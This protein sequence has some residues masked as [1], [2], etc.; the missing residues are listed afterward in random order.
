MT[1]SAE[2][3]RRARPGFSMPEFAVIIVILG[4]GVATLYGMF[5]STSEEAFKSQWAYLA[6]HAAREEL[7]ATRTM[8][9]FGRR[10]TEPYDG[11]DWEV[12]GGSPLR[13]IATDDLENPE[14]SYPE[15][16]SRIETKVEIEGDPEAR[17]RSVTLY[18]RYQQ[19]G[20]EVYGFQGP[21]GN[22][23]PVGVYRMLVVDRWFR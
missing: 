9:L 20:V 15:H 12:V 4:I 2:R 11:H 6:M 22:I 1:A 5:F 13:R 18:V 10:G 19:K 8:N 23:K 3:R 16:M 7:E 21:D 14:F 17:V